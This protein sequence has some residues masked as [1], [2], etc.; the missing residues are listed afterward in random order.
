[1]RRSL[2]FRSRAVP[3]IAEPTGR[4]VLASMLLVLLLMA[5]GVR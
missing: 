4:A 3:L 5:F 2:S 1:M